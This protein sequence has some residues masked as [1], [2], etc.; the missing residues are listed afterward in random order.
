MTTILNFKGQFLGS[1][2]YDG[3]KYY[4]ENENS[5]SEMKISEQNK[6]ELFIENG[7]DVESYERE[8]TNLIQERI[9]K[10]VNAKDIWQRERITLKYNQKIKDLAKEYLN[11]DFDIITKID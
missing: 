11:V 6:R 5:E 7:Y 9:D 1:S 8:Y 4:F 3:Q 10:S 2:I